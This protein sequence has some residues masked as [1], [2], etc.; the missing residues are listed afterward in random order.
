VRTVPFRDA[1]IKKRP[2]FG[3][4]RRQNGV[5]DVPTIVDVAPLAVV[6]RSTVAR[7]LSEYGNA[8]ES[9]NAAAEA[10]N[11][12]ANEVARS[13]GRTKSIGVVDPDIQHVGF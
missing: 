11:Y 9:V 7:V 12:R 10:L 3:L 4:V 13:T 6:S 5:S 1:T 2:Q 8:R